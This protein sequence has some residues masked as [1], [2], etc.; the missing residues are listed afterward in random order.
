MAH[1]YLNRAQVCAGLEQVCC[2]TV[3]Q[4]VRVDLLRESGTRCCCMAG[5]PDCL[6]GDGVVCSPLALGAGKEVALRLLPSPPAAQLFEQL[7]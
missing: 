7:G 5:V 2:I 3:A 1:Q 6:V 4:G